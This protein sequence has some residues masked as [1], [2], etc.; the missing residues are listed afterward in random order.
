MK[1]IRKALKRKN[2]TQ[3]QLAERVGISESFLGRVLS[4]K[5]KMSYV[6]LRKM[7]KHTGVRIDVLVR[8]N[9]T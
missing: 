8:E 7:A 3:R 6:T 1:S 9:F 5:R 2:I 4:G